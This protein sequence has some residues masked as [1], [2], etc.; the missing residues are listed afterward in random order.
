MSTLQ[1][2]KHS[3]L[4]LIDKV[5]GARSFRMVIIIG[6]YVYRLFCIVMQTPRRC[7]RI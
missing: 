3:G 1:G 6:V 7:T 5:E 2:T 4:Q